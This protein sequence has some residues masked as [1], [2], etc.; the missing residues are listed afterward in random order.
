MTL[1]VQCPTCHTD[2]VW[3]SENRHRPFCSQRCKMIDLGQWADESYR[4]TVAPSTM[5]YDHDLSYQCE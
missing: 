1:T 2:V 3:I 5:E 4:S